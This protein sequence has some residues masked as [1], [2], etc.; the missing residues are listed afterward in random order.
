VFICDN[1]T[2]STKVKSTSST[3]SLSD[4]LVVVACFVVITTR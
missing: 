1:S 2:K 4:V 3:V